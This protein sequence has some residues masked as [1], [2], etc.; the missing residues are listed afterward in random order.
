M[1]GSQI[2][3]FQG[4]HRNPWTIT[5]REMC[6]NIHPI[7]KPII[8]TALALLALPLH[9]ASSDT[10]FATFLFCILFAQQTHAWSHMKPSDLPPAVVTLQNLGLLISTKAHG[11]HHKPPFEGNYCIVSGMWNGLLDGSRVFNHMEKYIHERWGV[12]PRCWSEPN[13]DWKE[14]SA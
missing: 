2:E 8:P 1:F 5:Y 4:H 12:E 9:S 10:F 14:E 7:C 6:N 11:A 13:D 3:G